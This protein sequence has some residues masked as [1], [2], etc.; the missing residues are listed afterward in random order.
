[1]DARVVDVARRASGGSCVCVE[2]RTQRIGQTHHSQPQ[3]NFV[4]DIERVYGP[5]LATT[6]I[7]LI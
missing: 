2:V 6:V 1:M 4:E 5:H 3:A 7:G